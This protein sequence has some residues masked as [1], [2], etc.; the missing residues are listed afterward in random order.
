[1]YNF[2]G[3][4]MAI[5]HVDQMWGFPKSQLSLKH[6]ADYAGIDSKITVN[7]NNNVWFI[8]RGTT[9][10]YHCNSKTDKDELIYLVGDL[11]YIDLDKIHIT[12]IG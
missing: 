10:K 11:M 3:S 4:D 9:E 2:T 6:N 5:F 7:K 1:M 8:P 12:K